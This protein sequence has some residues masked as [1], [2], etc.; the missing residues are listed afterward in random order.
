MTTLRKTLT[1]TLLFFSFFSYGQL[2]YDSLVTISENVKLHDSIRAQALFFQ[3]Q[4]DFIQDDFDAAMAHVIQINSLENLNTKWQGIVHLSNA[5]IEQ[6][7][8]NLDSAIALNSKAIELFREAN[9]ELGA[10]VALNNLGLNFKSQDSASVAITK[11]LMAA[12][13]FEEL[14]C[15]LGASLALENV[16]SLHKENSE[17]GKA[18]HFYAKALALLSSE[19]VAEV[20]PPF[21]FKNYRYGLLTNIGYIY[22]QLGNWP[23]AEEYLLEGIDIA[24]KYDAPTLYIIK[25]YLS[26]SR[27]YL[28][29]EQLDSALK[30]AQKAEVLNLTEKS[31]ESDNAI[32]LAYA[33]YHSHKGDYKT[34]E[35]YFNDLI[36]YA[37][38]N[39]DPQAEQ[40]VRLFLGEHYLRLN[41]YYKA[42]NNCKSAY[43]LIKATHNYALMEDVCN[44]LYEA[45]KKLNQPA[46]A[47]QYNDDLNTAKDSLKSQQ[48]ANK[49]E[50][51]EFDQL[52]RQDSLVALKNRLV[53]EAEYQ[54][55]LRI[56]KQNR[57]IGF[58]VG[59]LVIIIAGAMY[60][61]LQI[62]RKSKALVEHE[63]ERSENLL[64]NILPAEIAQE[65]KEKGRADAQHFDDVGILFSD[66][67]GFTEQSAKL[68]AATLVE[69]INQCFE[70][71]DNIMDKYHIEKIKTIGDA[72]MAAGGL[73][74]PREGAVKDTVLAAIEMQVFIKDRKKVNRKEGKPAFDMRVGI[75]TGPVV[76]GIVGVKKFQYDIWGDTV[77]TASRME[78]SGEIEKVNISKATYETL[79]DDPEF[80]FEYRGKISAKGKGNVEMWFVG[81]NVKND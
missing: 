6:S 26:V 27:A 54:E 16:G 31:N 13:L 18:L 2:N 8:N 17:N 42:Q 23:K 49:L 63:K 5:K 34:A 45:H 59:G 12:R 52:Q 61:R 29:E 46:L 4:E 56:E 11:Y 68:S 76:A 78:S 35:K 81:L 66:F 32:F 43:P 28:K 53:R 62:I 36:N 37:K 55:K 19:K 3:I 20:K 24:K 38:V 65:L 9:F 1:T 51:L 47:L 73:P 25:R 22:L 80:T 67:K 71:F 7:F 50:Q 79:K 40:F 41:Q 44:C 15:P 64:L 14:D 70:A 21:V 72:Y 77:N 30:Y 69:E 48:L 74:I 39:N 75:H 58:G 33:I 10:A 57:N 60:G